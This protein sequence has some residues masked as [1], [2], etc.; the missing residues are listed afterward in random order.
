MKRCFAVLCLAILAVSSASADEGMWLFNKAPKDKIQKKYGFA[1]TDQ[2]L[3][4]VQKSSVRF[5]SGGSGS[6]VSPMGLTFTNHHVAQSCLEQ[7]ATA[8]KDYMKTGFYAKT[9]A[10]ELKCPDI[11]LNVLMAI[12][13]VT[14]QVNANVKQG[15]TAAQS[16]T[17]QRAAQSAIESDCNKSTGL[18]CDVVTFYSGAVYNLYKY[19]K[20]NDVRL[21][22]AP[23]FEI[24]FFG[25][26]P[27]N[28]EYPRYDLD[29][30]FFRVYENNQPVHLEHSFK[31]STTGV[32]DNELTFV[33]GHPGS[34]GKLLTMAQ[35]DFLRDT[36]Y[37]FELAVYDRRVNLLKAWS[38]KSDENARRAQHDIFGI[39]NNIKRTKVYYSSLK[40][41][42]LMGKKQAEENKYKQALAAD[43]KKKATFGDPWADVAQAMKAD[44]E[45]FIAHSLLE[46][47]YGFR[48]DLAGFA[49]TLIRAAAEKQK[50]NGERLREYRESALPALENT[51]FASTPQYKDL[52][53]VVLADSLALLQEKMPGAE[54]TKKA[55]NGKSPADV[56]HDVIAGTKLDEPA[57]RRQLYEGGEQAVAASTDPL[58]VLMRN[59]DPDSRAV[60][61]QFEDRVDAVERTSG[62]KIAQ[63]RFA[64]EGY[65][66]PPD[67]TFTLRLSYGPT[68]GYVENGLGTAPKGTKLPYFTTIGG[69]FEH[70][71]KHPKAPDY[72]LPASWIKAKQAGKLNLNTPFDFVNT[73][74]IIGGSSGS[75]VVNKAG[76]VVGIIFDSNM[77]ALPW[78]YVYDD[79]LGRSVI[80]DARGIIEA[81]RD[82]YGATALADELTGNANGQLVTK[83]KD[84]HRGKTT[85]TA[86]EKK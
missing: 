32:K 67:A 11:E 29:V 7:I 49:R 5:N 41:P 82:V 21:V 80:V 36:S 61:K 39:E 13:D 14:A 2:W 44:Q 84:G 27:D 60:R 70:A 33:S 50:P 65:S 51:L 68:R 26:D 72:V 22:F 75:P 64:Q 73:A 25:G 59:V 19:K 31:W 63:L 30:A 52:N 45:I 66:V 55:L 56:A 62:A 83:A 71:A 12:E 38:K 15:M 37:P 86:P 3:E 77:Q 9:Q 81:L 35:L 18:R 79:T 57:T 74:E 46:R 48:G 40:D 69:A 28:F 4:H 23:E 54:V 53:E 43:A 24:A 47:R 6:F 10:E 58:I 20:Y 76:E 17:A 8:E 16:G 1:V 78:R 42:S 85:S 34:T